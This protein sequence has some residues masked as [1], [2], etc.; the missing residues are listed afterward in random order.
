MELT[1]YGTLIILLALL[2]AATLGTWIVTMAQR[3]LDAAVPHIKKSFQK[4][5]ADRA[6]A[7]ALKNAPRRSD[8]E[9]TATKQGY[10]E[11]M[12]AFER[13]QQSLAHARH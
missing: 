2:G 11:A 4:W 9:R 5:E 7:H 1:P 10:L 13:A 3:L 8:A 6:L 12:A